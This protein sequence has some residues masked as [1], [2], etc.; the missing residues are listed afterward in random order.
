MKEQR[1]LPIEWPE[2]LSEF[3][4]F[5]R[6]KGLYFQCRGRIPHSGGEIR[7]QY[8]NDKI[9]VRVSADRGWAWS[10]Q[11]SDIAG[12]PDQWWVACELKD[13]ITGASGGSSFCRHNYNA[14]DGMQVIQESQKR[15][16]EGMRIIQENWDEIV[17]ALAPE[18]RSRTHTQLKKI[19]AE[20][21]SKRSGS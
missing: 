6:S 3:E 8:G 11:V 19:R 4:G 9:A 16:A 18:N 15:V 21:W 14:T 2:G 10:A 17:A 5:L 12:W 1:E 13:L 20:Y 7:W